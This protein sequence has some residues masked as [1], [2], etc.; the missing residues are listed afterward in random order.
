MV[1]SDPRAGRGRRRARRDWGK[2]WA[3]LLCILFALVGIVPLTGGL[4]LRLRPL[5]E[6]AASETSRVLREQLGVEATFQVELDLIPLRLAVTDLVVPAT[7][8]GTPAV[9]TR[10]AAVSPRFFSLLAG[11]LDV[12]DIELEDSAVRLVVKGGKLTNVAYRLP[13]RPKKNDDSS[14]SRS[15]FRSV[16]LTNVRVDLDIDGTHVVTDAIDLDAFAEPDLSFDVALRVAGATASS[17]HTSK[18]GVVSHD[19]DR[20]CALDLRTHLSRDLIT[21]RRFSLLG[22]LDLDP[23]PDTRPGCDGEGTERV[24]VRLSQFKITP[25]PSGRPWLRGRVMARTPAAITNRFVK[26]GEFTGWAGFAGEI[27][28]DDSTRLPEVSGQLSGEK[29]HM[30]EFQITERIAGTVLISG[31]VVRVPNLEAE[32]GNGRAH[33]HDFKLEPFAPRI[34]FSARH[35]ES[36]DIDF[37]GIM[38]AIG[39]TNNTIVDWNYD[40]VDIRDTRGAIAPFFLDGAVDAQ[41][42]HFAVYDRAYHDPAKKRM[43]GVERAHIEGRWRANPQ[44]LD[45]YAMTT[46][47]GK[48]RLPI[49]LVSVSFGGAETPLII[50]LGEGPVLDLADISP[51]AG[52]EV[53]GTTHLDI[54]LEGKMG[55]PSLDGKV[56]ID[57]LSIGG[58]DAGDLEKSEV[59]FE[60]LFVEFRDAVGRRGDLTFRLPSAKLDFDGPASVEFS[61]SVESSSFV[62]RE[63]FRIFHFDEDPR[64]ADVNGQGTTRARVRYV[65]GGPED[66]CDSG[67]LSV[68]GTA[69]FR[70]ME[71]FG[72]KF[73][74]AESD[75]AFEWFDI[76]A[77]VRGFRLDVPNVSLRKGSGAVFGSARVTP[78]GFVHAELIGT[79]V[80]VSRLDALGGV[81]SQVDGFVTGS[82]RVGGSLERL[83]LDA[84]VDVTELVG[85]ETRLPPSRL[86]VR[87]EPTDLPLKKSGQ[88]TGCGRD[89][90]PE[91]NP[92]EHEKDVSDGE[93]V[94]DG[95]LFDGQIRLDDVRITRQI[96]KVARGDVKFD[97]LDWGALAEITTGGGLLSRLP[98]GSMTGSA[99]LDE[100]KL[101]R[102]F[103][104]R[105]NLELTELNLG[106]EGYGASLTEKSLTMRLENGELTADPFSIALVT[107]SGQKGVLDA[108]ARVK[109]DRQVEAHLRLRE[110][111]LGVVAKVVPGIERAEGKLALGIDVDGPLSRPDV[112]GA[113]DIS[114]GRIF[115]KKIPTPLSDLNVRV[116]V[117]RT[118]ARLRATSRFGGG[119]LSASGSTPLVQGKLGTTRVEFHADGVSLPVDDQV[120]VAFG[121]DLDL[122]VPPPNESETKGPLPRLTGSVLLE[123]ASYERAMTAQADLASLTAR[124][125]K[126][127]VDSYSTDGDFL[128]IDVVVRAKR[129]LIVKNDLVETNLQ[130]DPGGLRISGTNQRFGAVGNVVIAPGGKIYLRRNAFDVKGGLV[131]FN[132]PTRLRPE[133]DVSASTELRRFED[134]G[135]TQAGAATSTSPSTPVAGSWRILLRA[136]GPPDDLRV[137]LTSDPPLGQ[138]DIFLL[139]TVGL[140]RAEL[141]Q[142]RSSGVGGSVALEALGS[143]SGAESAVTDTVPIDEFRF[144]STYSA[145]T[146]RTEPTVTIGKRLSE[147]LRASVTTSLSDAN[148]VRS[149]IEY[150]ATKRLSIEGSYDNAQR[151]GAPAAGNLGGDVRW[152]L[153][154]E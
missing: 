101:G 69:E 13:E 152:R 135:A 141:D 111:S 133:V 43:V 137:D 35:I 150:R 5:Q 18:S 42:S 88:K 146:G 132:D 59:H 110:T 82:G 75:F 125:H 34:P 72:E 56:S 138:D 113:L 7:D 115:L 84:R 24:A 54:A 8:G 14:L 40:H 10:L 19:E 145:R 106:M 67:R 29:L 41:T 73:S 16:T 25:Q 131:R 20:L 109:K 92:A 39:V 44:S 151:A 3:R 52:L 60:P 11:R 28:W 89:I 149:N 66:V 81:L 144:G 31:D 153:E 53:K 1:T 86:R 85:G 122:E 9:R 63:F 76:D 33:V 30:A 74:G 114:G 117:D 103:D 58:F 129:P 95:E 12:G 140:T 15:P 108:D 91:F 130:I 94:L 47:F 51:L 126:S 71:A 142:T 121:A 105:A 139:L 64:F 62:L 124:G 32:W 100:V 6:W 22:A 107:P 23:A 154:F 83:A 68:E 65:L 136:Y 79:R 55:H 97:K 102:L 134:R 112:R 147:R 21:I 61:S 118:G 96:R 120:R 127:D 37:P 87:L 70:E 148:E 45:F 57:D 2:T 143:L 38:Q 4:V 46:F 77:G 80:P 128:E 119:T 26:M 93:F 78:G 98:R 104:S 48:S 123:S 17:T 90:P 99:H 27:A 116:D 49:E 50:R 36:W